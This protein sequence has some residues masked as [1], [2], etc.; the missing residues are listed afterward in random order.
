MVYPLCRLSDA[1]RDVGVRATH[2]A[3]AEALVNPFTSW[4]H[5]GSTNGVPN[6]RPVSLENPNPNE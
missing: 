3:K 1:Y 5:G 2:E 6:L 4:V